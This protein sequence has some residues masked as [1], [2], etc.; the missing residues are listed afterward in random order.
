MNNSASQQ[1]VNVFNKFT[2]QQ[3]IVTGG[4]LLISVV[5]FAVIF[6][7]LNE[8]NYATLYSNLSETDASKVISYLNSQKISYEL[9]NN[10]T[11]IKVPKNKMYEVRFSLAGKGIPNS[12]V[13]GYEIFDES[14][15]GMS[16][17]MQKL[18]Y[19]RALE[20]E[21]ARTII[22]QDGI[23]GARVLIVLPKKTVFKDEEEPP[24]ASVVI[25][26][27]GGNSFTSAN[28]TAITN[29]VANSVEGLTPQN[30]TLIDTKGRL[31]SKKINDEQESFVNSKQYEI[32]KSVEQYLSNK[33]QSIL[34]QVIGFA[35]STVQ[36]NAD[37]NFNQVEKT[38]E[39]FDPESQ[40][41][42]SE[43]S[44]KNDNFGTTLSDSTI[45]SSQTS[46]VNYEINKT[47]Q[48]VIE[49]TGNVKKLS[50]AVV[51]NDIQREIKKGD[52]TEVVFEPRSSE[53]MK[54]L[55][56]IIINAVGID[57]ERGDQISLVNIPFET[58]EIT[59]L[60]FSEPS[61]TNDMDKMIKYILI[62]AAIIAS[63]FLLKGI[64]GKLKT[65]KLMLAGED[66]GEVSMRPIAR[67]QFNTFESNIDNN[68]NFK[69]NRE[70]INEG[71][72][73]DEITDEAMRK[74]AQQEKIGSY[75]SKNPEDAARLINSWLHEGEFQEQ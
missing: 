75:V 15:M 40:V 39:T 53:Q 54:K 19:K 35:N 36:V 62:L 11:T 33:V 42:I 44:V 28:T 65:E 30:V 2:L 32:K 12:G 5:I 46:T 60:E 59:D 20:G 23:E 50:I 58:K 48:R 66:V 1:I 51:V 14:T 9:T 24:K 10:G 74:K 68:I 72:L 13:T 17:F 45:E 25:K 70:F 29:L 22:Q 3:K 49:E 18:N 38:M 52:A 27:S 34:D 57:I 63:I 41:A 43:Q 67:P 26:L 56:T 64:M 4:A 7:F 37:F 69:R 73:E 55:E 61:I 31:L 47:V 16:E 6:V 71:D 8:P 21:L